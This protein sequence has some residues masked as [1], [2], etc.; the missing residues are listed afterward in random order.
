LGDQVHQ[1]NRI[2]GGIKVWA[3][4]RSPQKERPVKSLVGPGTRNA[5]TIA[6]MRSLATKSDDDAKA[7]LERANKD[8]RFFGMF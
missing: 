8:P 5:L 1:R 2:K 7:L 3:N 4:E 6:G